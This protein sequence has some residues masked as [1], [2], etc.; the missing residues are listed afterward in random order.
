MAKNA[1]TKLLFLFHDSCWPADEFIQSYHLH[2]FSHLSPQI[3]YLCVYSSLL[4][5]DDLPT[6]PD[7]V[8]VDG[9][10]SL[11]EDDDDDDDDDDDGAEMDVLFDK[12]W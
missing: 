5:I 10:F 6:V 1:Y 4:E 12:C 8:K 9:Y 3:R 7:S 2:I 11:S